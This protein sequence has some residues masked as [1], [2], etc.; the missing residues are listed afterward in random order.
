[1]YSFVVIYSCLFSNR[2]CDSQFKK[3]KFNS[4]SN[5]GAYRICVAMHVRTTKP[6]REN[7][8][9]FIQLAAC[10]RC[11]LCVCVL[12]FHNVLTVAVLTHKLKHRTKHS[13]SVHR[14]QQNRNTDTPT[15]TSTTTSR[16]RLQQKPKRKYSKQLN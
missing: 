15:T 3:K 16:P 2:V 13:T 5:V 10:R 4:R 8:L 7:D 11:A 6:N 12:L 1:M 9:L 14:T